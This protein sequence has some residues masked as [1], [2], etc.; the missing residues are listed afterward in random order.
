MRLV[1]FRISRLISHFRWQ[2]S[3]IR[4][5][6]RHTRPARMRATILL[7]SAAMLLMVEL[8]TAV[9][10]RAQA[11][12]AL[13][14]AG[15]TGA[16][17]TNTNWSI[18]KNGGFSAGTASWTV[19]VTKVSVSHEIIE[20]DGQFRITNSGTGPA[21]LGNIVVNL[22]RPCGMV[23]VSAAADVAD[24]TFG[25]AATYGNFVASASLENVVRNNPASACEGPGNYV[26]VT[27]PWG[28]AHFVVGI[29][30]R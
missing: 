22:Q 11:N 1:L 14:N 29:E 9:A 18:A 25:E 13:S 21:L 24:A 12:I 3:S 10:V 30:R 23:W 28:D 7:M 16:V 26:I 8:G 4:Q 27:P 5:S 17:A 2:L 6:E 15:V 20:V 19:G